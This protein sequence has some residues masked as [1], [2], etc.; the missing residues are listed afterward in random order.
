MTATDQPRLLITGSRDATP[1]MVTMAR[2]AVVRAKV[3]HWTIVVGD[4]EGVDSA[5]VDACFD[6]GVTFT[7]Y[8]ITDTPR[9]PTCEFRHYV[10]F[11]QYIKVDGPY[12]KRDEFMVEN[13]DRCFAVCRNNSRGTM[14]TYSY[15]VKRGIPADIRR[16]R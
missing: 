5:V 2:S 10:Q 8:G 16:F 13:A 3:N 14:Y 6:F 4:A 1:N 9:L 11:P 15:A 7:C 12:L